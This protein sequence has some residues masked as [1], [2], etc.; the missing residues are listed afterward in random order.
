MAIDGHGRTDGD[1]GGGGSV[2][3]FADMIAFDIFD[4]PT[5]FR[6]IV[7]PC[8]WWSVSKPFSLMAVDVAEMADEE[9]L[10][11][12]LMQQLLISESLR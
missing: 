3:A 2:A 1:G 9:E 4:A 5:G 6:R 7:P 12:S 8:S 11:T 10:S